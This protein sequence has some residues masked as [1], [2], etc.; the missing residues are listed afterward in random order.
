MTS[1]EP[2]QPNEPQ[3]GQPQPAQPQPVDPQ[4]APTVEPGQTTK[5]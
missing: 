3:Q 4:P 1:T 2:N 5:K